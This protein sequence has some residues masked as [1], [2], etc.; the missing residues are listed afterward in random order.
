MRSELIQDQKLVEECN[1]SMILEDAVSN[2][3]QH[4]GQ[5]DV[6]SDLVCNNKKRKWRRVRR[7]R[8]D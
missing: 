2:A 5:E 4:Q 1:K 3:T 6:R 8:H 7:G